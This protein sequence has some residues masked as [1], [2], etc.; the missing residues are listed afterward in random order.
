MI[1]YA[2]NTAQQMNVADRC[3]FICGDFLTHIFNEPF[4]VVLALGF[5]DYIK[6]AEPM[7]KKIALLRPHKFAASFPKFTPI[8]GTQRAIRYCWFKKCPVYNYTAA[9]LDRLYREAPFRYYEIIPCGKG[10]FGVAGTGQE[11]I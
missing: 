11:L 5:F 10:F 2:R 7:F 9:Q 8:W 4:D 6:N 1:E 3:E